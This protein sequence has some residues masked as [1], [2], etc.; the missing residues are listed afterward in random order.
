[1]KTGDMIRINRKT[2][3]VEIENYLSM[4][5]GFKKENRLIRTS[6]FTSKANSTIMKNELM[7][8]PQ[9]IT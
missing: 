9:L 5:D 3:K 8:Y 7:D 2:M 4:I 1:M 6:I